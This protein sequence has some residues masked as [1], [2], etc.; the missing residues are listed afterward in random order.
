MVAEAHKAQL[1]SYLGLHYPFSEIPQRARE[2]Y[3]R[4]RVRVLADTG[5]VA[6]P[7]VPRLSPFTNTDI[8]MSMSQLRSL[9]PLHIEYLRNMGVTGTLVTSLMKEDYLWGLIACHH[10]APRRLPYQMR[11]ACELLSEV[12][13]TR[14]AALD[15]AAVAQSVLLVP[16][17]EKQ[18]VET[19]SAT[20]DW[21]Q[22]LFGALRV[23]MPALS[24]TGGALLYEGQTLT[25]GAVPVRKISVVLPAGLRRRRRARS[26]SR[27]RWERSRHLPG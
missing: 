5:S 10:Y 14:L 3:I 19:A 21:H 12:F 25:T 20:G 9:S 11:A 22:A 16:R 27:R 17:L 23:L 18:I 1:E 24:A 4:N 6:V 2:L 7:L 13:S 26:S 15:A 8:D